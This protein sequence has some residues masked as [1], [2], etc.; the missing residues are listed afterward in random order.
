MY[1][2]GEQIGK[3]KLQVSID[4]DC[5]LVCIYMC[6]EL[7]EEAYEA[8]CIHAEHASWLTYHYKEVVIKS[9]HWVKLKQILEARS[10]E[11]IAFRNA[12]Q[13][14]KNMGY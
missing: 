10:N 2:L 13:E 7:Y 8:L 6:F 9:G 12:L 11:N 5:Y 14:L 3:S 4:L 1:S